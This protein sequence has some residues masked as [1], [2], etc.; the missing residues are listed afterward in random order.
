MTTLAFLAALA[1]IFTVVLAM[2][3]TDGDSLRL[4]RPAGLI[5]W[6]TG[7]NWPAKIG[8]ALIIVGVGALL[9]YAAINIDLPPQVKLG[10]GIVIALALGLASTFVPE[11]AAKRPVSLALGGAAF[12]VAYLTAYSAFGLFH[13]VSNPTGLALLGIT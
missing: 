13:Y 3:V 12:G 8:G 4:H 2:E 10:A 7:G 6:L 5:A 1:A 9:R 11:G